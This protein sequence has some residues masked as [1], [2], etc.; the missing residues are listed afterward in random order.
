MVLRMQVAPLNAHAVAR[1]AAHALRRTLRS[2]KLP[3]LLTTG[4]ISRSPVEFLPSAWRV[5]P[6]PTVSANSVVLLAAFSG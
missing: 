4:A 2:A 5:C 1:A 6:P 3:L